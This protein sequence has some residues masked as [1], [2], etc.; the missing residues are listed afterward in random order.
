M[1]EQER[2]RVM[3]RARFDRMVVVEYDDERS[4][5]LGDVVD[6]CNQNRFRRGGLGSVE[7]RFG[8][9]PDARVHAMHPG[10]KMV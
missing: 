2:Y 9:G 10:N 5:S 4:S 8:T 6:E 3:N 1:V 7:Q